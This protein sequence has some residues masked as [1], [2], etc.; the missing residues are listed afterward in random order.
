MAKNFYLKWSSISSG[1]KILGRNYAS[2][3][4][5]YKN[6]GILK[7]EGKY[8]VTL[9]QRKLKTPKGNPFT[10]DS[11]PLALAV[12]VEWNSQK[13]KII[14]SKMHLT[15]LCNTILDNPNNLTKLDIVNYIVNYLDTDTV[16]FQCNE[17]EDLLKFQESEWDPVIDWFNKRFHVKLKKSIQMDVLPVSEEDKT[18][19]TRHLM[20]YNFA[21]INGFVYGVD[22]LKSVILTLATIERFLTP[23]RAV[24]LSRLEEEY[25]N[26]K[27]GRIEWAHDLNQQELL[28]R[29][30]AVVFFVYFNSQS[31]KI[32][33]KNK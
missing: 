16:L 4:R 27:W 5:F 1:F 14:Q 9:D 23:D 13:D 18:T 17:D 21:A 19:L 11:E 20:S 32:Q 31:Q 24:L 3:N 10:V 2:Q 15:T 7:S 26:G 25:Q 6:T 30:S 29:L 28:A 33:Q 12:S 8:E 22:T